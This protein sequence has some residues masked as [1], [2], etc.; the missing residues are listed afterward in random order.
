MN[1]KKSKYNNYI[2]NP[3]LIFLWVLMKIGWILSDKLYLKCLYYL[4]MGKIL[5][6]D[7]PITFCEKIQWLKLYNRK[8]EFTN[9]VDKLA[10]KDYVS[11]LIGNEYVIPTIG[12]F[13]NPND[14]DF[15]NLP[16]QFIL[17]TTHGGGSG[18][19]VICRDK[20]KFD[21]K[22]ALEKLQKSLRLDIYKYY[23]EW[24]YQNVHRRIIAE[25]FLS[26]GKNDDLV[27][28]KF[29]CFGGKAKYCQVI[30]DRSTEETIDF[31]DREWNHQEFIG[32]SPTVHHSFKKHDKPLHYN[33]M[34]KIA[35]ELASS[36][37][38]PF[39]RIDLY[40]ILGKIYFG[41]ITFFPASGIGRFKPDYWD[42]ILG[43][44]INI[45]GK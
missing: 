27:D 22:K 14:I 10:V 29:F 43:D 12:I 34:L 5:N 15:E 35:D 25:P 38:A 41:E 26:D 36:V 30:M 39:V 3:S 23:R 18:G 1:N 20:N 7:N 17:K 11:S 44:L 45:N 28:Y 32:L 37:R 42:E 40:N 2:D 24:P 16:D 9:L 4:S 8:H 33:D 19:I 21:Q 6:L 31:F 13:E